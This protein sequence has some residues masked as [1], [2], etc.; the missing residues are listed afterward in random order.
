MFRGMEPVFAAWHDR[1][2]RA[3]PHSERGHRFGRG[4]VVAAAV[5]D[6]R[7]DG[8]LNRM[9]AHVAEPVPGERFAEVRFDLSAGAEFVFRDVRPCHHVRDQFL[10]VHDGRDEQRVVNMSRSERG[11]GKE[12]AD[13]VRD[14][15]H[16]IAF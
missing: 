3:N 11:H 12:R 10:H 8:P 1:E 6:A 16:G 2:L 9:G 7:G 5:Q 4:Q 13:A 14:Q 15:G